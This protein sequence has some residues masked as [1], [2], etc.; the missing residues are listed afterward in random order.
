MISLS[1]EKLPHRGGSLGLVRWTGHEAS[2][3]GD[4]KGKTL[5]VAHL[6]DVTDGEIREVLDAMSDFL[7]T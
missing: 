7:K 1:H 3:Q 2:S 4:L 6:G 5:R